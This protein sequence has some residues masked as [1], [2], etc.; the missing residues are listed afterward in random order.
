MVIERC[1]KCGKAFMSQSEVKR[2]KMYEHPVP[3]SPFEE[4]RSVSDT[5]KDNSNVNVGDLQKMTSN[6]T[7]G[8]G[9]SNSNN[10]NNITTIDGRQIRKV[11]GRTLRA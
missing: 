5:S 3:V 2:H 9:N 7:T 1:D 10:N 11:P 8:K 4:K 6:V